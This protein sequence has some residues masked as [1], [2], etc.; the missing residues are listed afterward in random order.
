MFSSIVTYIK[1]LVVLI[2]IKYIYLSDRVCKK[3]ME[4]DSRLF[5]CMDY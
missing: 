3:E 5:F 4:M 2:Q 1:W